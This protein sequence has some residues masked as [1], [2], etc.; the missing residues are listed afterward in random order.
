MHFDR[1]PV[2]EAEGCNPRLFKLGDATVQGKYG[3][4]MHALFY[5]D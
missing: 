4:R 5:I 2:A 3:K 1:P